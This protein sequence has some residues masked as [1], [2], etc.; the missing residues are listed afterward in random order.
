[1]VYAATCSSTARR[2]ATARRWACTTQ[3]DLDT[4][5]CH[6]CGNQ[7]IEATEECDSEA[8]NG[9][10]CEGLG[11]DGGLLACAA[12]CRYDTSACS[13]CGDGQCDQAQGESGVSCPADCGWSEVHL[14]GDHTCGLTLTGHVYCWGRNEFGQLGDSTLVNHAS[15]TR[16]EPIVDLIAASAGQSFSCAVNGSGT[17][18]CWGKNNQGQLGNGTQVDQL[19]PTPVGGVGVVPDFVSVNAGNMHACAVAQDTTVWCWGVNGAGSLGDGTTTDRELPVQTQNLS[20]VVQVSAGEDN[21][22]ARTALGE[23]WCWGENG[24][25]E[26]GDGTTNNRSSPRLLDFEGMGV[27][28]ISTG[29]DHSCATLADQTAWCWGKNTDGQ[30]GDGTTSNRLS[31]RQVLGLTNA[32]D[33]APATKHTCALTTDGEVWCWGENASGQ[34]GDGLGV[35]RITPGIVVLPDAAIQIATA[36]TYSCAVLVDQTAWC[37]GANDYGQLGDATLTPSL[38]PTP[39][40]PP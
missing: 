35:S 8:L 34:L 37:W 32:A 11:R 6:T 5:G 26:V 39:V 29:D 31:P 7:I 4:A 28:S 17:T 21:S 30:L 13:S 15:P 2:S 24:L 9:Q 40:L 12:D 18:W 36:S 22:C 1:V 33:I 16:V 25:G 38:A 23:G 3:C 19:T 27:A 10:T 20:G 14:L